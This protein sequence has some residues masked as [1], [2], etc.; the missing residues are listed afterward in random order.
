MSLLR[1]VL[2]ASLGG[3]AWQG[4]KSVEGRVRLVCA[5]NCGAMTKGVETRGQEQKRIRHQVIP[6]L[7]LQVPRG[8]RAEGQRRSA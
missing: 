1:R 2:C 4:P 6:F 8:R 7:N 5:Y 3:H